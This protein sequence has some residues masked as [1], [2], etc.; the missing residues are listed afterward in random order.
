M[1]VLRRPDILKIQQYLLSLEYALIG[2]PTI[3]ISEQYEICAPLESSLYLYALA[4]TRCR[5]ETRD[6][7][8]A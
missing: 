5:Y 6:P 7:R 1:I 3:H 2:L 8:S 4:N